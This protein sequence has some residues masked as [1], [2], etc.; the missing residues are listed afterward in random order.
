MTD[1]KKFCVTIV[2]PSPSPPPPSSPPS[3]SW[4]LEVPEICV[5]VSC[6]ENGKH[7]LKK[8]IKESLRKD[9]NYYNYYYE[10]EEKDFRALLFV[11]VSLLCT[12]E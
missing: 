6:R 8:I 2:I 3:P 10:R 5:Y 12:Y 11:T 4:L 7:E 1:W 9:Y